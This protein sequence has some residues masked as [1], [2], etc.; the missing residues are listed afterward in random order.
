MDGRDFTRLAAETATDEERRRILRILE[1][2]L[3]AASPF[4]AIGC[5]GG[6]PDCLDVGRQDTRNDHSPYPTYFEHLLSLI[7]EGGTSWP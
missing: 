4:G 3:P 7:E 2:H 1:D 6:E 5:M